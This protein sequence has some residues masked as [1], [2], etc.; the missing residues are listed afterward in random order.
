METFDDRR[1]PESCQRRRRGRSRAICD[2]PQIARE[3]E[4]QLGRKTLYA[5]ILTE[6][7]KL[8]RSKRSDFVVALCAAGRF[9]MKVVTGT[10]GVTRSNVDERVREERRKRGPNTRVEDL[11]LTAE[12]RRLVDV[13]PTCDYRRNVVS[14]R[15]ERRSGGDTLASAK[16]VYQLMK[17]H[18]LLLARRTGRCRPR[19]H[20]RNV[21][22]LCSN[23]RWCSDKLKFTCSDGEMVCIVLA[24]D[25]HDREVIGWRATTFGTSGEMARDLMVGCVERR[26][27]AP[28]AP[29]AVQWLADHGSVYVATKTIEI[30]TALN[31][32]SCFTPVESPESNGVA[33]PYVKAFKRD[34]VRINP[35]PN[36]EVV[37]AP[38]AN[39]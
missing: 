11:E 33:E 2:N 4:R 13:R 19:E 20:D 23:I 1:W 9:P 12:I 36:A 26:F 15:H 34:Y 37:L 7:L 6:A 39:W 32:Q 21:V 30:A 3:L 18:G 10:F 31:L 16:R 17:K 35:T 8:A 22:T 38:V 14:L 27:G 29:H 25:C 28:R 24:L 5:E